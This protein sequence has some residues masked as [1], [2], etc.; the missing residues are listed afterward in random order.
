MTLPYAPIAQWW[1][2]P[3]LVGLLYLG[4]TRNVL[5]EKNLYD[6]YL[7][8]E[9]PVGSCDGVNTAART[10]NGVCNNL[11]TPE[12]GAAGTRF[13]RF[14]PINKTYSETDTLYTPNPRTISQELLKRK[15]FV[16]ATSINLLAAA[17]I[18]FQ[19]HDWFSHG[20]TN[21][22]DNLMTFDLP[23][24]DP[25]RANGQTT[26]S[27]RRTIKETHADRPNTY[28][29]TNTHWW[30]LS[31][32]YGSDEATHK[33]LRSFVDGK[34]KVAKDG[35]LPVGPSGI[36]LTGF[37]DDWWAGLSVMH[38]IWTKEHNL[39]CDMFKASYPHWTDTELFDHAR[40][41]TTALN[42]KIH[43]VEWTPAL[44]QDQILENAMKA[45]WYGLAPEWLQPTGDGFTDK[46]A[47]VWHNA[48][49]TVQANWY[50]VTPSWLQRRGIIDEIAEV[51]D[52]IIGGKPDFSGVRFAHSEEFV[53][54]YRFHSLLPDTLAIRNHRTGAGTG[55]AYNLSQYAFRGA[56]DVV[57]GNK[58]SD[59]VFTFGADSPGALNLGNYPAAML[60][61]S[62]PGAANTIDMGVIDVLR[63]RE[64]GVPRYNEFRRLFSLIPAK[65]MDDISDD[66]AA[67][68]ALRSVYGEDV[69]SV[70]LLPGSLAESPRATGF[71]FSNTQFQVFI[72]AASRRLMTD[73]F[74]TTDYNAAT[75][76]QEGLDYV[77]RSDFRAVIGRTVPELNVSAYSVDNAFK[78]WVLPGPQTQAEEPKSSLLSLN[79]FIIFLS[80]LACVL[81]FRRS[82]TSH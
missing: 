72:L 13:S 61:L 63:D 62:K 29:N 40:L 65:T 76:T 4:V 19:V 44:L 12:M 53:S 39:V 49:F 6:T 16:P 21:D 81:Y 78:P 23:E 41:V 75:Y 37:S 36:D 80:F 60:S 11:E 9:F 68:A 33:K 46:L 50:G 1:K 43:T 51:W 52:G 48:K 3:V 25:L 31:Q 71:A 7:P 73:R 17:W 2:L 54:I 14:V 70:D 45:N 64:R 28:I 22:P 32:I 15:N 30:D 10:L 57:H 27:L 58:F 20:D 74:F 8:G 35:L 18:Q 69:E 79:S 5:S 47:R 77:S 56:Q 26:M 59:V 34:M 38:N 55:N 67:V 82:S 24:N 66:K 42:A